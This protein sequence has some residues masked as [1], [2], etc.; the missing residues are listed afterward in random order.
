MGVRN[1]V[2]ALA[3]VACSCVP[4]SAG[5][6]K[7]RILPHGV[8]EALAAD[9]KT[10]CYQYRSEPKESCHQ[11]F[12]A[13]LLWRKVLVTPTGQGAILVESEN[14]GFCGA[15]GCSL[16]L[17]LQQPGGEFV[18]VLG[19]QGDTGDL[20]SIKVLKTTTKDHYNI[21]KTWSDGKTHSIYRWN[22]LRYRL[23]DASDIDCWR[24]SS[25]SCDQKKHPEFEDYS[26]AATFA[27]K[28]HSIVLATPLDRKYRTAIKETVAEGVNFAGQYV[29]VD[30]GCGT[31]CEE[32]VIV[33]A[34]T[35][36]VYDP[37]FDEV[38]F[39]YPPKES[40]VRWW[41]YPDLV[42]YHKDSQLLVVEG[43]FRGRQ[44]GRTY[45]IME[46]TLKQLDY[47]PDLFPDGTIAAH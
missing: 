14:L 16:Y 18:Q 44:C 35:G 33:D 36:T 46:N 20:E 7:S 42:N 47:D 26:V 28:M 3:L 43:C 38:D 10:Y 25:G 5:S 15:L 13:N 2:G 41:C 27:G 32:F 8:V 21:Q 22:G 11:T 24:L 39:H 37:P 29:V 23:A 17:F 40:D 34:K 6:G 30:W 12:R 45:F 31:G 9:E 4:L 19:T 1:I